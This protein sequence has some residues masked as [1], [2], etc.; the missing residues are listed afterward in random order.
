MRNQECTSVKFGAKHTRKTQNHHQHQRLSK[1]SFIVLIISRH[2]ATENV[3]SA[4]TNHTPRLL[5]PAV[6]HA[7]PPSSLS[8]P[9]HKNHSLHLC[10]NIYSLQMTVVGLCGGGAV[11]VRVCWGDGGGKSSSF[12]RSASRTRFRSERDQWAGP[13]PM[14]HML[15]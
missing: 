2:C 13:I 9:L 1:I 7:P 5:M 15:A 4:A 12:V 3:A 11:C 6:G 8:L 14:E 10:I